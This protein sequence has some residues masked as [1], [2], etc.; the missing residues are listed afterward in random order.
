MVNSDIN[1]FFF[2]LLGVHHCTRSAGVHADLRAS[3][4][5]GRVRE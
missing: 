5:E 3:V 2:C 1:I 4:F